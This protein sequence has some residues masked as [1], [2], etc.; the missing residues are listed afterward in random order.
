MTMAISREYQWEARRALA[1]DPNDDEPQFE[2]LFIKDEKITET[3][4]TDLDPRWYI[5]RWLLWELLP[6]QFEHGPRRDGYVR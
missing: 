5:E 2:V 6:N 1:I 3:F 4:K